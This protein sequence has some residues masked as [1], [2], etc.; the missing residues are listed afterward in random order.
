MTGLL[1]S[2]FLQQRPA[3]SGMWFD[4]ALLTRCDWPP[5]SIVKR[6]NADNIAALRKRKEAFSVQHLDSLRLPQW[7][8]NSK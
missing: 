7:Q 1:E 4:A 6:G 5:Q 2:A 8:L 3:P